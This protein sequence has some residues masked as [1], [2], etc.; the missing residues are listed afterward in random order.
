[1]RGMV[2]VAVAALSIGGVIGASV[3][4]YAVAQNAPP[5]GVDAPMHGG[6]GMG[7]MHQMHRPMFRGQR[8]FGLFFH[9]DDRKLTT[10]DVQKIAEAFL[11]WQGNRTWKVTQVAE[12]PDNAVSFALATGDGS[13]IARFSMDRATGRVK[14][15]G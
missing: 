14:R 3:G 6:P 1:M 9:P 10:A 12:A 5:P 2:L 15:T 7:M 11:L 8:P 4:G 13:V